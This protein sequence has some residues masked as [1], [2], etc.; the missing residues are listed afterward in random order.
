D[1]YGPE[2]LTVILGNGEANGVEV[3]A[4]TVTEGDPSY[5]GPLAGVALKIPVYHILEDE[6]M[7]QVPESLREEKLQLSALVVDVGPMH[8]VL[9]A[10]RQKI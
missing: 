6:V 2:N 5:A 10:S 8:Q 1:Q 4:E 9:E 3:F 7:S